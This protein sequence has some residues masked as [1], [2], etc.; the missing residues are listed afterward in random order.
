MAVIIYS[1]VQGTISDS[2]PNK[3][4]FGDGYID[5]KMQLR[6]SS[7]TEHRAIT[8]F[9]LSMVSGNVLSANLILTKR[10]S[11]FPDPIQINVRGYS[12]NGILDLNDFSNRDYYTSVGYNH[13]PILNIDVT[14][15]ITDLVENSEEFAGFSLQVPT[16]I[17]FTSFMWFNDS[18]NAQSII[19]MLSIEMKAV[20]SPPTA[21]LFSIGIF[22]ILFVSKQ[23]KG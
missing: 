2:K 1:T 11:N 4:G 14:P 9:D 19:P 10:F 12:G 5:H 21:A 23:K 16:N 8:E 6:N 7:W 18:Y 22:S 3:D 17:Y 13:D 15:F 20:P